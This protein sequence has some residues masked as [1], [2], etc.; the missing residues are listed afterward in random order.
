LIILYPGIKAEY[1]H[2]SLVKED[3]YKL[4]IRYSVV[5]EHRF[6]MVLYGI[7]YLDP[8][9]T[10]HIKRPIATAIRAQKRYRIE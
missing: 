8:F 6:Y 5:I 7:G 10:N 9:H 1:E 2:K 3:V 4:S